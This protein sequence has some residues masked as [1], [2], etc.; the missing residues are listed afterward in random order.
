[1]L[2]DTLDAH[3]QRK[4]HVKL[5]GQGSHLQATERGLRRKTKPAST[6]ILDISSL[7]PL[8]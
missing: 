6:L 2:S 1:M 5:I 4:D 7:G 3:E 8:K